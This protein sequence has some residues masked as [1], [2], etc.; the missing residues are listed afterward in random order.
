MAIIKCSD[1][2]FYDSELYDECPHCKRKGAF[3]DAT[4]DN[5]T[6]AMF[7][8]NFVSE[9]VTNS[10]A[11]DFSEEGSDDLK[12]E[13]IFM[14]KNNMN[15]VSGWL[16]GVEGENKGRSFEIHVNNNFVGR[17]M[18][19]DIKINDEHISREKHFSV[20]YDPVSNKF[21]ISAGK[22]LTHHNGKIV[23]SEAELSEGDVIKAG[24]SAYVFVPYCREGRTWND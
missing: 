13:S 2:H 7:K 1:N 8:R 14:Q 9:G 11:T 6:V 21:F 17:S 20:V 16:V 23:D 22:G 24:M 5:K 10:V 15:P 19:N 18:K 3:P 12:T 4:G